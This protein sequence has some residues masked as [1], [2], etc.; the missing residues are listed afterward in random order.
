MITPAQLDEALRLQKFRGGRLGAILVETQAV[1]V[2]V[3]GTWLGRISGFPC[4]T[5]QMLQAAPQEV[6]QLLPGELAQKLECI[7]FWRDGRS[8]H[9]AIVNPYSAEA[10]EALTSRTRLPILKYVVPEL[11]FYQ[12]LETHYGRATKPADPE[13]RVLEARAESRSPAT[14]PAKERHLRL[15]PSKPPPVTSARPPVAPPPPPAIPKSWLATERTPLVV[16]APIVPAAEPPPPQQITERPSL[17]RA[18]PPAPS[19]PPPP[20][21]PVAVSSAVV[22]GVEPTRAATPEP[23]APPVR[24]V[25]PFTI[26]EATAALEA[27]HARDEVA[28]A[29]LRYA[30][31]F[32]DVAL[33]LIVRDHI[34][35]G[36]KGRGAAL[37][38]TD[39]G[40]I[41]LS[42]NAPSFF[43]DAC[44]QHKPAGGTRA[45]NAIHERFYKVLGLRPP[46]SAVVVPIAV[47]NRVVNLLY[48]DRL[49]LLDALDAA[50]KLSE[51][52]S[53]ASTAY[54]RILG[55][56]RQQAS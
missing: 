7:P 21:P 31:G 44:D 27:A 41:A 20:V 16:D 53:V 6:L 9:V 14:A 29:V 49:S 34:A 39:V 2:D 10:M 55:E 52:A 1:S 25:Q 48:G 46:A 30:M 24:S 42:L 22:S 45:P 26:A 43:K 28:D 50:E 51:V 47:G 18:D 23:V 17:V 12:F 36:W 35:S 15:V 13:K 40:K 3:L 32:V 37:E 33:L 8:L 4:A 19:L 54:V 56:R 5:A 38:G 11:L